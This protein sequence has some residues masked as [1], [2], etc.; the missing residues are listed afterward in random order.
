MALVS[1]IV[2]SY[3]SDEWLAQCLDS[4]SSQNFDGVEVIVIDDPKGSGASAARNRGLD[5]AT[6]EFVM[7]CDADDYL[8]PKAIETLVGAMDGVD[9]VAGSFRKFGDFEAIVQHPTEVL[10]ESQVAEYA[11]GNLLNPRQNQLLSGCWAKL[12]RMSMVG[13]FP[14]ITTAEDMA[15]NFD[16]LRNCSKVSFISDVVYHNR[17]RQGSLST[18]FDRDNIRGLFGFLPAMK[19]MRDF[20]ERFYTDDE[21]ED[22]LDNSKMYHSMLYFMRICAQEGG[23]QRDVLCKLFP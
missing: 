15:F 22:A 1:V 4:I 23:T 20:L 8:A 13:R 12:Y 14:D 21:I 16:Y 7:F 17:K 5:K 18:T 2:P 19:Y 10:L 6:G 3:N 9:M 11:M